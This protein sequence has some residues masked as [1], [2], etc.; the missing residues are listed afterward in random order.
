MYSTKST[1]ERY[2]CELP[3]IL[4]SEKEGQFREK[5]KLWGRLPPPALCTNVTVRTQTFVL[6]N[7]STARRVVDSNSE[8]VVS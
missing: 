4:A 1:E 5:P 3:C 6:E 2:A 7:K 8:R